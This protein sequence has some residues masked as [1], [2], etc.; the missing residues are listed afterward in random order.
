MGPRGCTMIAMSTDT[1]ASDAAESAT[2]IPTDEGA[3]AV[4]TAWTSL[5][6]FR[7]ATFGVPELVKVAYVL[8]W[9]VA[10]VSWMGPVLTQLYWVETVRADPLSSVVAEA[11]GM[12]AVV[13][14]LLLGWI[15]A[16]I[17]LV[18]V[19]LALEAVLAMAV[20]ARECRARV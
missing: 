13:A 15:P 20:H 17:G 3:V 12:Q 2:G 16:L 11:T 8:A 4:R 1:P 6:D 7:F 10:F 14:T 5:F 19:R 9:V 18:F